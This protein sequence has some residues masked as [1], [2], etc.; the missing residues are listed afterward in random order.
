MTQITPQ[1]K[2]KKAFIFLSFSSH[3]K[4]SFVTGSLFFSLQTTTSQ[5][6]CLFIISET[7][8]STSCSFVCQECIHRFFLVLSSPGPKIVH[9]PLARN[10]MLSDCRTDIGHELR[11]RKGRYKN[12]KRSQQASLWTRKEK[13]MQFRLTGNILVCML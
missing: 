12:S 2:Q 9:L 11:R 4:P 8:S 13:A 7:A 3:G 6:F 1:Y 10:S 5:K